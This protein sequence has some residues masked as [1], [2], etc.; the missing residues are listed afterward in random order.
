MTENKRVGL[1]KKNRERQRVRRKEVWISMKEERLDRAREREFV[2]VC[3]C[4]SAE[5]QPS[6]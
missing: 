6:G 3:D 5:Q 1:N 2:I 4:Q